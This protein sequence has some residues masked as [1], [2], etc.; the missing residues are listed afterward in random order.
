MSKI[1][2]ATLGI[3]MVTMLSKCLGLGREMVLAAYYS[4]GD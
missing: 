2:K 1:A 4:V 3:M